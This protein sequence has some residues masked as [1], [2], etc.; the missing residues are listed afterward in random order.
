MSLRLRST[1]LERLCNVSDLMLGS[2]GPERLKVCG[3]QLHVFPSD[4]GVNRVHLATPGAVQARSRPCLS[5]Q[6]RFLALRLLCAN[7]FACTQA[8]PSSVAHLSALGPREASQLWY[9]EPPPARHLLSVSPCLQ[10]VCLP[11]TMFKN[12]RCMSIAELF[13]AEPG[14]TN[15]MELRATECLGKPPRG[16]VVKTRKLL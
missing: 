8:V 16:R 7:S 1:C 10:Q 13:Q 14:D 12:P 3:R 4:S 9:D 6:R 11:D 2:Q 5:P 15:S